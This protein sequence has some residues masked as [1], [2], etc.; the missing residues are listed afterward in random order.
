MK[1]INGKTKVYTTGSREIFPRPKDFGAARTVDEGG[2]AGKCFSVNA[3][4]K[5]RDYGTC[6]DRKKR[7][8]VPRT[9]PRERARVLSLEPFFS[10]FPRVVSAFT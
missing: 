5:E 1:K 2:Y 10:Q 9:Q 6:T 4:E 8:G 3:R 7:R